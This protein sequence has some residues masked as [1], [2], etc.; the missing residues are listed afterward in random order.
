M[1]VDA[2][3]DI[4]LEFNDRGAR[5]QLVGAITDL[6]RF[7]AIVVVAIAISIWITWPLWGPRDFPIVLPVANL[8]Q[9]TLGPILIAACLLALVAPRLGV[10]VITLVFAYGMATD[11]TRMQPEFFSLPLLLWGSLP[12]ASAQ[13]IGRVSL[14]SLWF[15]AGFHKLLSPDYLHDAGPRLVMALPLSLP[16]GMVR[17]AV[18]GIALLEMGTATLALTPATRRLAAWSALFLHTGILFAFSPFAESRNVAVWP[19][20][21]ALACSG[22]ALIAPWKATPLA[23]LRAVPFLPRLLATLFA[24]M[25]A[26]YYLGIVDAYPAYHLY[27]AATASATVYC[28]AGCRPDQDLNASWYDFNVPLPPEP[29]LFEATFRATCSPGDVLRIADPHPPPWSP[30]DGVRLR[31]CPADPLP[32]AQP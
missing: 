22:F 25:P 16:H 12:S 13:L 30:A 7:R 21:I 4:S 3:H 26:G 14:I 27:S 2:L 8:P 24:V 23:S 10:I 15:F 11:Q 19:W 6:A 1:L 20:N 17:F 29:R 32:I 5:P 31:S 28:P 18:V 9:V